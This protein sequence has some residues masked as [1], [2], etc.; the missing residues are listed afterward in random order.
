[1]AWPIREIK[2]WTEF[3]EAVEKYQN[4]VVIPGKSSFYFRGQANSEWQLTPSLDRQLGSSEFLFVV[5][6]E[7][8]AL[9]E[10]R[11]HA[12]LY[13]TPHIISRTND[14]LGWWTLMQHYGVPTR[15]LDWSM[16]VFIATYFAVDTHWDKPGAVWLFDMGMLGA[17][18]QEKYGVPDLS[19]NSSIQDLFYDL[20]TPTQLL[21]IRRL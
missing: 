12:H 10:F 3:T 17:W 2:N 19:N 14:L 9:E 20:R 15:V 5:E 18:T 6:R 13:L 8:A 7:R 1:M 21:P 11:T 16:S 4:K